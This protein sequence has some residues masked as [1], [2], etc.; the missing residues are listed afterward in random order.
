[1]AQAAQR[2]EPARLCHL[3]ARPVWL[4]STG[5]SFQRCRRH[6]VVGCVN[7]VPGARRRDAGEHSG[8]AY[9]KLVQY[10]GV[11]TKARPHRPAFHSLAQSLAPAAAL[12]L[13]RV[14]SAHRQER[15]RRA[16]LM[17][18]PRRGQQLAD[19]SAALVAASNDTPD[20]IR[21]AKLRLT[22]RCRRS[23]LVLVIAATRINCCPRRIANN[24][25]AHNSITNG[26]C[27]KAQGTLLGCTGYIRTCRAIRGHRALGLR[28]RDKLITAASS[29]PAESIASLSRWRLEAEHACGNSERSGR[30]VKR[31]IRPSSKHDDNDP[32]GRSRPYLLQIDIINGKTRELRKLP[33]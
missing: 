31:I 2:R 33:S 19:S 3:V 14:R 7:A 25:L 26:G 32:R 24:A 11:S 22:L 30:S 5:Q 21:T 15:D 12:R 8:L 29:R 18:L 10:A 23:T 4:W 13:G 16:A 17:F 20:Y 28:S 1:M 6:P 9:L 27:Y